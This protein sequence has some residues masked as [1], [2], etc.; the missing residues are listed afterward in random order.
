MGLFVIFLYTFTINS[1]T[2]GACNMPI[3]YKVCF[4]L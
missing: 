4:Y 1:C 2:T 3:E